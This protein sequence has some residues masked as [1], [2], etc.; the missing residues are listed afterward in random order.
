MLNA[1][2]A[3]LDMGAKDDSERAMTRAKLYAPPRE[4]RPAP[5]QSGTERGSMPRRPV[6]A[7]KAATASAAANTGFDL[8]RAQSL[9][10]VIAAEN[11]RLGI[12][13]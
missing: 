5:Q 6:Q 12:E 8:S 11:A 13:G 2:E 4:P 10:A 1:Y 9:M 7:V 3:A